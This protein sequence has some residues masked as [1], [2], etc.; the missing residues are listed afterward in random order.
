MKQQQEMVAAFRARFGEL[1]RMPEHRH[2]EPYTRPRRLAFADPEVAT[3]RQVPGHLILALTSAYNL[4][5]DWYE[6]QNPELAT[7][8][9]WPR[10][11]ALPKRTGS[12]KLMAEIFRT[13][14]IVRLAA[15]Q[16][17]GYIEV[18]D[19]GLIRA[20]CEYNRC[21]LSLLTTETG[22]ELLVSSVIYYLDAQSQP[23]SEAYVELMLGQYFTDIVGEIRS[24]GDDDRVLF[25]FRQKCW[26]NRHQRFEVDNPRVQI[27]E[28]H[29]RIDM[30]RYGNNPAR[31]PLD[32]Y[33]TLDDSLYIVPVEVLKD[34]G[35]ISAK[36]F[37]K[38]KAYTRQG[39]ALPDAFRLRFAHEKNIVGLP[40]T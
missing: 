28:D 35:F 5:A 25:Q 37:A 19:N 11:L 3:E 14:R 27:E 23:H 40:M 26:F 33:I 12:E 10:Y 38:W 36:D 18:K 2:M 29:Y 16:S 24:F 32:F 20:F 4:L 15:I 17:N 31:Y 6:C 34:D 22:L 7:L 1:C 8:G 9:S 13:L 30:G 39:A 21:A